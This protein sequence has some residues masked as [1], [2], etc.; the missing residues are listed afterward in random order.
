MFQQLASCLESTEC[1]AGQ[2]ADLSDEELMEYISESCTMSKSL[3]EYE[4]TKMGPQNL[5]PAHTLP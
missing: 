3:E 4:G 1:D 5:N 2:G